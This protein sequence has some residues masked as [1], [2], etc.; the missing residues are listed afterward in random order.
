MCAEAVMDAIPIIFS[1]FTDAKDEKCRAAAAQVVLGLARQGCHA[2]LQVGND[3][4]ILTRAPSS[5]HP[6]PIPNFSIDTCK[7]ACSC[8]WAECVGRF[9]QAR[10]ATVK[11]FL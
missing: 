1:V 6:F 5:Q 10:S 9:D 4:R 2:L 7:L 11:Q 3:L 8:F